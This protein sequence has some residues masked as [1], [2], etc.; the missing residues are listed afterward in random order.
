MTWKDVG[1]T[2]ARAA[3]I[4]AGVLGGPVGAVASAAGTLAASWL[5]EEANPEAVNAALQNDPE[6]LIRLK[7]LES[8]QHERLLAWQEKQ[9]AAELAN[10][11]GARERE[12][13][14]AQAGHGA[15]WATTVVSIVVTVGVFV[16]PNQ[17]IGQSEASSDAALLLLGSLGTAFG[18]V[19]NYYL[20]SSL[21]SIQ[22]TGLLAKTGRA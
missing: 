16:M 5:G 1:K 9:L 6:A 17:V 20:G 2:V 21:G 13:K 12:V 7:E 11:Q 4:L 14:L 15:A 22:K 8:R 10:V 18:A 19:I 3:P